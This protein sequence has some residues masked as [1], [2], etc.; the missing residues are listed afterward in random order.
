M[1][2]S[3]L[4]PSSKRPF[5][6]LLRT[7]SL[8]F[9][10]SS[11]F[12]LVDLLGPGPGKCPLTSLCLK[13]PTVSQRQEARAGRGGVQRRSGK[14]TS[15]GVVTS[16]TRVTKRVPVSWAGLLNHQTAPWPSCW[17]LPEGPGPHFTSLCGCCCLE[18]QA[19][20]VIST[21]VPNLV[22]AGVPAFSQTPCCL[23]PPH[24]AGAQELT[25]P[26]WHGEL[27]APL[28]LLHLSGA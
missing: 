26:T 10:P 22:F 19:T 6:P 12:C 2:T 28:I 23:K 1:V 4:P 11:E 17:G 18:D 7:T 27:L 8:P 25:M 14:G 9:P 21:F 5:S 24:W 15:F 20:N 16:G 3:N 13:R